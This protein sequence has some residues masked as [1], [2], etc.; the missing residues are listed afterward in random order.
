MKRIGLVSCLLISLSILAAC[1]SAP[2]MT[3]KTSDATRPLENLKS[4]ESPSPKSATAPQVAPVLPKAN[5]GRGAYYLDDGPGDDIPPNLEFTL[6]PIPVVEAYSRTGNKPYAVFG[7]TYT[8]I[9]DSTS[10]FKQR[11]RASWYGKKFH[12]KR[13]SSGETYDMYK[14][15]AAHPVLPIPSFARVTNLSNG[16]QIIVRINDRGPFHSE[17]IM[18]LSYTAALKLGILGKGSSE[19]EL[20]RLLPD[21]IAKMEENRKNQVEPQAVAITSAVQLDLI[22]SA[23]RTSL[24]ASP[25]NADRALGSEAYYLQLAA[26]GLRSNAEASLQRLQQSLKQIKLPKDLQD[27]AIVQ[28]GNLYRLQSGPYASREA[29]T[30]VLEQLAASGE[31]PMV[32]RR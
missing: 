20:E 4:T 23:Q 22:D 6:D 31:R 28:Q 9:V 14:V 17:R 21:D 12:G 8:P 29:A 32:V 11:G 5:S 3:S 25:I 15:T 16:K 27:F 19:V 26:F 13:T 7:K 24:P 30:T 10:A 2:K 1:S 18:D